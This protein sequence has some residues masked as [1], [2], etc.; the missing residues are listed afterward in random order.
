MPTATA[1]RYLAIYLEDH[2]AASVGAIELARRGAGQYRDG[3]LGAFLARLASEI[4]ED[5]DELKRFAAAAGS[6]A[7]PLKQLIAWSAEKAGR[8]K[9]NGHLLS[10]SPL[11]PVVELEVLS[12]GVHGKLLLW[13]AIEAQYGAQAP[14]GL[15]LPALRERAERQLDEIETHRLA[16]TGAAFGA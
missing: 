14:G 15:D 3:E 6:G 4:A 10:P 1:N 13:R 2:L 16:A 9:L 8:L 11:S 7:N 12:L 5:H